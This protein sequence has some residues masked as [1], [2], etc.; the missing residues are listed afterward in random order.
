MK[1]DWRWVSC[2]W[3]FNSVGSASC[4][5]PILCLVNNFLLT[6]LMAGIVQKFPGL[7]DTERSMFT[8]T[9]H[10]LSANLRA[11]SPSG[12]ADQLRDEIPAPAHSTRKPGAAIGSP[13]S[14]SNSL[15]KH[16]DGGGGT[17]IY[18]SGL[19]KIFMVA[20]FEHFRCQ[21]EICHELLNWL[22]QTMGKH[23]C[24]PPLR[25]T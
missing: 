17:H 9:A 14:D 20:T 2:L 22:Q 6:S 15:Q 19:D 12:D 18:G 13:Q 8:R 16:R 24:V 1:P 11:G 10:Q 5:K 4:P 3:R 23:C 21:A 7:V 25:P